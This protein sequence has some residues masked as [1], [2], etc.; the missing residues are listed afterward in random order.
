MQQIIVFPR[1][2]LTPDMK[3]ELNEAGIIALEV[4]DPEKVVTVLPVTRTLTGDKLLDAALQTIKDTSS[5]HVRA[6]FATRILKDLL[7]A[8]P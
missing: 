5:A 1:G 8:E 7:S 2:Q 4:D 3:Q 6:S